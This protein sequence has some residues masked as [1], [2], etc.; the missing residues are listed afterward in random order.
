M[1][2]RIAGIAL[3]RLGRGEGAERELIHALELARETGAEYDIAATID[4]LDALGGAS[5][6][7]TQRGRISRRQ[8]SILG[9]LRSAAR[10][11]TARFN[12]PR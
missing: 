5:P 11:P 1:L 9:C 8:P 12:W 7:D 6:G 4:I 3:C 2:R 10:L